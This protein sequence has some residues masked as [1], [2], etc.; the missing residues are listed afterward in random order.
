MRFAALI[1]VCWLWTVKCAGQDSLLY[2]Y[3]TVRTYENNDSIP[4]PTVRVQEKVGLDAPSSVRTNARGRY[5]LNL[6]RDGVFWI[7]FDA[8]GKVGKRLEIDTHGARQERIGG[9]GMN[10]DVTLFDSIPGLDFSYLSEPMGRACFIGT[11]DEFN[12]D[13]EYTQAVKER[14]VKL[15]REY[16]ESRKPTTAP[17]R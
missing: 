11:R 1:T 5:E 14:I 3:G 15:M 9:Y 12:W 8:P 4:F 17:P 7:L 16:D 10:A 13:L 2:V 6:N